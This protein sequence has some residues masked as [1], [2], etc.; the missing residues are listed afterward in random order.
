[1]SSKTI[2]SPADYRLFCSVAEVSQKTLRHTLKS[3]LK[4]RY[5]T[6]YATKDYIYAIG[7]I[8]IALCAHMDTVFPKPPSD[9]YYDKDKN[10]IWSPTGLGADDRAGVFSILKI[11]RTGLRPTVIFLA[12]EEIGALGASALIKAFP[13]PVNE[14]K[15]LIELDRRGE[16]DCVFYE[17]DNMDFIDYIETF[18]FLMNFGSFSDISEICPQWGIAGVNLS[19]GYEGEHSVSE[20]LRVG[21]MLNTIRRVEQMLREENI[22]SFKYIPSQY[23]GYSGYGARQFFPY[24]YED[25]YD[26]D[27]YGADSASGLTYQCH[28]CHQNF[29]AHEVL[30]VKTAEG[31]TVFLCPDCCAEAAVWCN[32]CGEGFLKSVLGES[33][34]CPDCAKKIFK[35]GK[36]E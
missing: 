10:V 17:C 33:H 1:M 27:Y 32:V 24:P 5:A 35:D 6:V 9:I 15:Y 26:Y 31:G 18:G 11:L 12:D 4:A 34:I 23:Y 3:Y 36:K 20:I 28:R 13:K 14:L 30:P 7:D 2:L 22:P 21:P 19:V 29:R 16:I 25:D 8:P